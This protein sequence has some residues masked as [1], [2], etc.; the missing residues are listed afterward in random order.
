[1]STRKYLNTHGFYDRIILAI[2]TGIDTVNGTV[3]IMFL[4]QFGVRDKLPIPVV[5]MSKN[6][7]IRFI[8][9]VDDVVYVGLRPDDS[10]VILGW[11]PYNYRERAQAFED[12][13]LNAAGG[14]SPE[15]MQEIKQGEIDMR[16]KGGGYLRLNDIGDV[17]IMSL[18]GRIRMLGQEGFTELA[19]LGLK[20]TDGK[21][22]MRF[23]APFRSF[24]GI[25]ERELPTAGD[26]APLNAPS[27]LRE[28]DTRL[29]DS[30][31]KLLAQE[32]LGTVIDE[33]GTMELSGTSGSGAAQ[34]VGA[35][36]KINS[37]T[38]T[39]FSTA[40]ANVATLA[41]KLS[42]VSDHVKELASQY[43]S[44]LAGVM[45]ALVGAVSATFT[46]MGRTSQLQVID[47]TSEDVAGI[48]TGSG[49]IGD[50]LDQ[51]RGLGEVGKKLRYRLL[52]NR[53]GKQVAAYDIDE[54]GG[55]VLSSE[56]DIGTTINANKGGLALYAKKGIKLVARG[57]AVAMEK[58]GITASEDIRLIA[59]GNSIRTAGNNIIDT[60]KNIT[61]VADTSVAIGAGVSATLVS[62]TSSVE[63]TPS[64]ITVQ[65]SGPVTI[66]GGTVTITGATVSI[67]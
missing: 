9:Q 40:V 8:P 49:N 21:S 20:V 53:N 32:S 25:S 42:G 34:D 23:G 67:N 54:N 31:G 60:A 66:Q 24:P 2:V 65:S 18:A 64:G 30:S 39:K 12:G 22:T 29:Y 55:V 4:D 35:T 43:T 11:F 7:W 45:G 51:I 19:Q 27:D 33:Q 37:A 61:Q 36:A 47:T 28:R 15:M 17:L 38:T 48:V 44:Q 46:I 3:S 5:A 58:V 57:L 10:A 26:G 59:G 16:S 14:I 50:G 1:M 62:D 52:I 56:S 13:D 6:A 41:K 63:V